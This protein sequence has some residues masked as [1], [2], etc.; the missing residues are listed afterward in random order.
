MNSVIQLI[1]TESKTSLIVFVIYLLQRQ[2][3]PFLYYTLTLQPEVRSSYLQSQERMS[4]S[5]VALLVL[6][7]G[8]STAEHRNEKTDCSESTLDTLTQLATLLPQENGTETD[9]NCPTWFLPVTDDKENDTCECGNNLD[10]I[11]ICGTETQQVY[12]H[13]CYCMSNNQDSS[14]LVV[15]NCYYSCDQPT[16][17]KSPYFSLPSN[18]SKLENTLCQE[19]HREGQ[20][21]G[22]CNSTFTPPVYSYTLHCVQC[23]D[24]DYNWAKYLAV[25]FLPLTVFFVIV[26]TFRVSATS[27]S[28]NAFILISQI[29]S[30][31]AILRSFDIP[32]HCHTTVK[33]CSIYILMSLY[34]IW[35]LDFFR[36]L[37]EPFCL[38]PSVTTLQVLALDYA[39]A[40]FPLALI[41]ITYTLMEL[42]NRDC[43][44]I[45]WLWRPF[46]TWC[47]RIRRLQNIRT[48]LIDAF[49]TFILLSCVKFLSVPF[50]LLIPARL[51]DIH[52]KNV[53]TNYL[54]Y[55]G[56]IEYFG[57]QHLP[58]AI[59][60]IIMLLV[61]VVF[62]CLLL[63]LF[64]CRCFQRFIAHYG[65]RS[66]VLTTF[67]D[68]FQGCYKDGTN[69]TRD[70]RYFAA[71]YFILLGILLGSLA[72]ALTRFVLPATISILVMFAIIIVIA[73]PYKSP[74]HNVINACLILV[75]AL[76]LTSVSEVDQGLNK[77]PFKTLPAITAMI[78]LIFPP[79]YGIALLLYNLL[80]HRRV[81]QQ[82]F[83]KLQS[84]L[85]Y[86]C[87]RLAHTDSEDSL[88]DR[89]AHPE[90]YAALLAE[91]VRGEESS[92]EEESPPTDTYTY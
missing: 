9:D 67:M 64:P 55:D 5:A 52:G 38:H 65:F 81:V 23:S 49:A 2:K 4:V 90:Q 18:A 91:P 6:V 22:R 54:Y 16:M 32:T 12:L 88:P 7:L 48:S 43:R 85:P 50:D 69:G 73:R 31:P 53:G 37:Y 76:S 77:S 46:H 25:A 71:M 19:Y 13:R 27:G 11:V 57:K 83:R 45:V 42:H 10:S 26:I 21:C 40:I 70:C 84:L 78:T 41:V 74:A 20:L 87:R 72:T 59:A 34:G 35:N 79:I 8:I 3:A 75:T 68:A 17:R 66:L 92:E 44:I 51:Y 1:K 82:A 29:S 56:T 47:V 36:L 60:A 62:P 80:A 63:C 28:M 30:T 15:G 89:M 39:I 58:Y 86:S 33:C 24:Y 61:F 14:G